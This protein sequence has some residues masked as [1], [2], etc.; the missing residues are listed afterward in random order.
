MVV[1]E[2]KERCIVRGYSQYN[3]GERVVVSEED[4]IRLL[5]EFPDGWKEIPDEPKMPTSHKAL[6]APVVDKMKRAP[7]RKK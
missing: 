3:A 7:E 4:A 5:T 2:A 1:L 6:S